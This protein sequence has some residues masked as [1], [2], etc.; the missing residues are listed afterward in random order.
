MLPV[1][2]SGGPD[3][4]L[5]SKKKDGIGAGWWYVLRPADQ[6]MLAEEIRCLSSQ[7]IK[8]SMKSAPKRVCK[9]LRCACRD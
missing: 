8:P 1:S 5:L 2:N 9:S 7:R 4:K 6:G 3:A